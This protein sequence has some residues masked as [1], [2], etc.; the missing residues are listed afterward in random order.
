MTS[1]RFCLRLVPG[2][3]ILLLSNALMAQEALDQQLGKL[4]PDEKTR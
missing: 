1:V 4:D 3:L 2:L